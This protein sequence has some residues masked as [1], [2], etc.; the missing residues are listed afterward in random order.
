MDKKLLKSYK[1]ILSILKVMT[2]FE[3]VV[4]KLTDLN[5]KGPTGVRI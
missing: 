5:L 3:T 4:Y 2:N 1:L